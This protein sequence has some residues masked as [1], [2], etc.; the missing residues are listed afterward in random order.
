M[1]I[2]PLAPPASAAVLIA[3]T[4]RAHAVDR[5]FCVPG[6]SFLPLLDALRDQPSIDLV[7]CRHE[8]SA[9]LAAVAD[10]RLTGRPGVLA[11]SR[12]P[13][14]SNAMIGIHAA[15]QDAIPLVVLIGQ[16][17]RPNLGRGAFQEMDYQSLFSGIAKWV[18][19]VS[20]AARAAEVVGRAFAAATTGTPG[21]AIVVLPEDM[22]EDLTGAPALAP[23]PRVRSAVCVDALAQVRERLA[24]AKRP[25]A[26]VGS[27]CRQPA[28]R[29]ALRQ[30]SE[31]WALPVAV[32]NKNQD[33]FP[34]D[35]PHWFGHLGFFVDPQAAALMAEAD[36]VL[37]IGTRL[38]DVASQGYRFPA[39]AP[40]TRA[41]V[42]VHPDPGVLNRLHAPEVAIAASGDD[43]VRAL[44]ALAPPAAPDRAAWIEAVG[45]CRH[46]QQTLTVNED[47]GQGLDFGA[48]VQAVERH[49]RGDAVVSMDAG[50][51]SSWVHRALQFQPAQQM[52][53]A[54]CGAMGMAVP[55]ALAAALRHP[56]R[57]VVA[58]CGDGGFLMTGNELATAVARRAQPKIFIA[59]NGSY[60]TIRT[61]Q[62]RAY[63]G[64][65]I[66]TD[67]GNPDFA[68]LADA[69]GATGIRIE[70]LAQVDEAVARALA[71]PGPVVVDV[72][73]NLEYL[74]P[75][76]R[77]SA[78][79]RAA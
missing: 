24:Q 17:D 62:E 16:V 67:L 58:F 10:G 66:G 18:G 79:A 51:F 34:N 72:R 30:L 13:G 46:A 52:V 38:G 47:D 28:F 20:D 56:D 42:H 19:E 53:A 8:G 11:V 64:R 43:F 2:D 63:P 37:A 75:G 7:T 27:Q 3:R 74:M 71:T 77:L 23:L 73:C 5:I 48:V 60:G 69:F 39:L 22:L 33:L 9:A 68:R 49:L 45:R 36:L 12:G 6:E 61:Y 59:N 1:R 54:A 76:L 15:Q 55:G 44:L 70:R 32:T 4:L 65:P 57:Q 31:A 78:L 14:T 25:L 26:I 41:L 29:A 21:P 40:A 35:H 50:N